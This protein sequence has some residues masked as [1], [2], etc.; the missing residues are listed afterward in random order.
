MIAIDELKRRSSLSS[1]VE[2]SGVSLRPAGPEKLGHCP[3]HEDRT[4]SFYV[5]DSKGVF[6]CF[7]CGAS[8]DILDF[9]QL[10]HGVGFSEAVQMAGGE[11]PTYEAR[12]KPSKLPKARDT[13]AEARK[14]W[15]YAGPIFGTPA[16]RYLELRGLPLASFPKTDWL[17]FSHAW[18]R[19]FQFELPALLSAF[20]DCEGNVR[21]IQRTYIAP[22]GRK[23]DHP[24]AKL[25]LGSIRGHAIRLGEAED[26]LILC[27]GLE[28]A[29][30]LRSAMPDYAVWVAGGTSNLSQL[31]IP[32][33]VSDLTIAA[34]NDEAGRCAALRAAESYLA[35]DR[36]VRISP[37]PAGFKDFNEM[38]QS[39][40]EENR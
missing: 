15:S 39:N 38:R 36:S 19:D 37:P 25:S 35:P 34:D 14:L 31:E 9:L 12:T 13:E 2:D 27:E 8:G 30:T 5:N 7:G 28:D 4:P 11:W 23:I 6:H 20:T 18:H 29:L 22:D 17:R 1:C 3:F 10:F 40:V 16:E 21:G 24:D 32:N 33:S 26:K